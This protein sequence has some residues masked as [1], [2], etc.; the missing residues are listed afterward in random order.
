MVK[1]KLTREGRILD[2]LGLRKEI[3]YESLRYLNTKV[4][5]VCLKLFYFTW[6]SMMKIF[7]PNRRG[8]NRIIL[9]HGRPALKK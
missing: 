1:A 9:D 4:E 5:K 6:E 2:Y 7:S 8:N 3:I